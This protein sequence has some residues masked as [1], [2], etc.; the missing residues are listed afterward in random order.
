[1]TRKF[2]ER[3]FH[4][5]KQGE[6]RLIISAPATPPSRLVQKITSDP[7]LIVML[8]VVR[9][10]MY[11]LLVLAIRRSCVTG[12]PSWEWNAPMTQHVGKDNDIMRETGVYLGSIGSW[13]DQT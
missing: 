6:F 2:P 11:F 9:V 13:A 4:D 3:V 5:L 7:T 1:M 12:T 10:R 8:P